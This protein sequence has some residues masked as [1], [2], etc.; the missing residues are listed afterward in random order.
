MRRLLLS[1]PFFAAVLFTGCGIDE[2][3]VTLSGS[4]APVS[5]VSGGS[6]ESQI[7]A[8]RA[9]QSDAIRLD[10]HG[11]TPEQFQQLGQ[12]CESLTTLLIDNGEI[13][14]T[15][16]SVLSRLPKLRQLKLP[17]SVGDVGLEA[18]SDCRG[19]EL[20]NLPGGDFSDRGCAQL[21][22]LDQLML[23]RFGSPHVTD[24]GIR[25][26]TRL[27]GLRFLHL[28][29]VPITDAALDHIASIKTL[30]S[31]YLD[32]GRVSDDGL[33][34]LIVQRPDLHVHLD[35]THIPGDPN[36]HD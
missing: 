16:L 9:G 6:W 24:D 14:D 30:E 13:G 22:Q 10:E 32:G 21:A 28:L 36:A 1:A 18:I 11:I 27:P 2:P 34:R 8:V 29:D 3:D 4:T 12:G 20:L 7:A 25:S 15:E 35:Q 23:L 19:L 5:A 26:L 31:F 17:G 33:R